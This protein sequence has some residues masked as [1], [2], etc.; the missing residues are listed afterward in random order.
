M[1]KTRFIHRFHSDIENYPDLLVPDT[2][3]DR[4]IGRRC[5]FINPSC[6]AEAI[7]TFTVCGVQALF[8]GSLA[9]RVVGDLDTYRWG[10]PAKP[11]DIRFMA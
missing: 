7:D 10:R 3:L 11:H 9:Y 6:P 8:D 5:V 1:A 2:E 4:N